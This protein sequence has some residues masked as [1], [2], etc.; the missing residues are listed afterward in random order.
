[1]R[2]VGLLQREL[3]K[4]GIA[5]VSISNQPDMTEKVCVPRAAFI[6]YPF[7]RILGMVG[8]REGQRRVCDDMCDLLVEAEGP[9]SYVHLP[10]EWPEP[11]EKTRWHPLSPAPMHVQRAK[12]LAP[13]GFAHYRDEERPDLV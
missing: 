1:M 2:S 3:E 4:A 8:D 6:Q 10:Y 7:A 13:K 11:P 5:T 9:N 12:G